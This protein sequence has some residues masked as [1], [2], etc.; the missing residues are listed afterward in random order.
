MTSGVTSSITPMNSW[1]KIPPGDMPGI[2]PLITCRSLPQIAVVV[3]LTRASPGSSS[4]GLGTSASSIA[5]KSLNSNARIDDLLDTYV[6]SSSAARRW[7]I[8]SRSSSSI[9][10][11]PADSRRSQNG[12]RSGSPAAAALA[13]ASR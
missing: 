5:P 1:P 6:F 8:R 11:S 12:M 7:M 4:P 10:P 3:T 13:R 9:C 2:R